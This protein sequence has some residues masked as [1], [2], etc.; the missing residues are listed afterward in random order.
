MLEMLARLPTGEIPTDY[1]ALPAVLPAAASLEEVEPGAI[2]GW[3]APNQ[4]ISRGFGDAWLAEARS[5]ALLVPA[6][7]VPQERNV[8]INPHHPQMPQIE[9]GEPL[10]VLWDR[11]L[12]ERR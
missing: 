8:L 2:D 12:F 7:A 5:L 4:V 11:R 9:I 10:S 6:M 1:A 3:D